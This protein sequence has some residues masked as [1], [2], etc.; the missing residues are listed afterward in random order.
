MYFWEQT[1]FC[2]KSA[3]QV[4]PNCFLAEAC[5][6]ALIF[7]KEMYVRTVL[8]SSNKAVFIQQ[9]SGGI[10]P[11]SKL[12]CYFSLVAPHLRSVR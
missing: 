6:N 8:R 1:F 3:E 10:N 11:K 4:L 5:A 7:L 2:K 9:A 12:G